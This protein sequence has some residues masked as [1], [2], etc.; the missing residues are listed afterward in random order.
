MKLPIILLPIYFL[1]IVVSSTGC[2]EEP[3]DEEVCW[4]DEQ[5]DEGEVCRYPECVKACQTD[6][7]C[8]WVEGPVNVCD[9]VEG[10]CMEEG[11]YS[12]K[13][14]QEGQECQA[15]T[16][17]WRC[18]TQYDCPQDQERKLQ[19]NVERRTCEP[20]PYGREC[21]TTEQC[22]R[23]EV[24]LDGRCQDSREV[25]SDGACATG[26]C[27]D[28]I[29]CTQWYGEGFFCDNETLRCLAYTCR[30]DIYCIT[31]NGPTWYC[32]ESY[33]CVD[34]SCTEDTDCRRFGD[35]AECDMESGLC[36]GL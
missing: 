24:C 11:C 25:C 14:C 26:E 19:C 1:G 6:E 12:E 30:E 35:Q 10:V 36:I 2:K 29:Q 15:R 18:Q 23:W 16:C 9:V 28:S 27:Q 4:R 21:L 17:I 22:G 3:L 33:Y 34:R 13:H 8:G 31:Y 32:G 7:D 5:C 20:I